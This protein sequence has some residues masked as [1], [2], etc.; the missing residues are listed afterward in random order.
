[1][2]EILTILCMVWYGLK[3]KHD[4]TGEAGEAQRN[5]SRT[6]TW[7]KESAHRLAVNY[8]IMAGAL[9]ALNQTE[10]Q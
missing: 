4:D 2:H 8:H 7:K 1:M 10:D 9:G 6:S 3:Q 5:L